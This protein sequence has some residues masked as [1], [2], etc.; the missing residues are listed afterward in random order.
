MRNLLEF[1][2]DT[3]DANY[4]K[5]TSLLHWK[6]DSSS[7]TNHDLDGVYSSLF[8]V[9]GA[10]TH[11]TKPVID[12]I[13]E[14][15]VEC[16]SA[17]DGINFENKI[18]LAVA[19]RLAA[20]KFMVDKIADPVFVEAIKTCQTPRLLERY[21]QVVSGKPETVQNCRVLRRVPPC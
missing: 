1:M 3:S 10:F 4:I 8:G 13:H 20:D 2:N 17:G 12:T 14:S 18:V 15:A 11:S 21:E 6:S 5:L 7:I 9:S 16:L 19:T